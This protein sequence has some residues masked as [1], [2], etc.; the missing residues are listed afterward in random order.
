MKNWKAIQPKPD[1]PWELYDLNTDISEEHDV[2]ADHPDLIAKMKGFATA[3]H[4]P[5]RPGS[6]ADRVAHE[7]DRWAKYGTS[8]GPS[9]P[10]GK[11]NSLPKKGAI[12][13]SS[14][15]I[16]SFSSQNTSN[17]KFAKYAIDGDPRTIWHTQ[18]T[19]DLAEAPHELVIDLGGQYSIRAILYLTRQDTGWNG[20]FG[21]C[22]VFVSS[23]GKSFGE[24]VCTPT[25]GKIKKAQEAAFPETNARFVKIRILS[26]VN[27]GPW[28]SAAEI[29][30]VGKAARSK[31]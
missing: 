15:K 11:V 14:M 18:F 6:F 13:T 12:A 31:R 1:G 17:Q 20:S 23:D 4:E 7:R 21:K 5:V 29:G 16:A 8:R 22:E 25:F 10:T 3:A 19:P 24:P 30:F 9:K 2:A 27:G 26:E 28:A